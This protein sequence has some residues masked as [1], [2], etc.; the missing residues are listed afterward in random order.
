L[1]AVGGSQYH[2]IVADNRPR[3]VIC[4]ID[5]KQPRCRA[6]LHT[7]VLSAISCTDNFSFEEANSRA[8]IFIGEMYGIEPVS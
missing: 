3:F 7:P 1:T 5:A 4:K 8:V 2:T 6:R